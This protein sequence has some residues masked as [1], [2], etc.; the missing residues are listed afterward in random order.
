MVFCVV[1]DGSLVVFFE[2]ADAVLESGL[3]GDGLGSGEG[4]G[5]AGEGDV[6]FSDFGEGF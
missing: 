6:G 1:A 2:A 3:A 4:F 5:I